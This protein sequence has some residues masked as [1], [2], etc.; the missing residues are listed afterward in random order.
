[1]QPLRH[2]RRCAVRLQGRTT[3]S[4]SPESL[5]PVQRIVRRTHLGRCIAL[6]GVRAAQRNLCRPIGVG[7][8]GAG[9]ATTKSR[10][11]RPG[12]DVLLQRLAAA[13]PSPRC[14]LDHD[15]PWTLLIA[16]ILSAQSTDRTVNSVTP[17]L[18][19]RWPTPA[20]LAAAPRAEV[21]HVV[22]RTGF[23]RNKAKAIQACSMELVA[24]HGGEVPRDMAALCALPGVARKTAN[25]VL[26]IACH[27][28]AGVV[29]DT[30]VTRVARR[31]ALTRADKADK[32]E[33]DL[34]ALLPQGQWI[35]GG[36]RLLLHGRYL[37]TSRS[38]QCEQCA[39]AELCP[40]RESDPAGSWQQRAAR[41]AALV[42]DGGE[43]RRP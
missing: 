13:I 35:E 1:M 32:I 39:L 14:E 11:R 36:H 10:G 33:Q 38:P 30:H 31:L 24:R 5:R 15:S 41:E 23:F 9:V 7:R 42:R 40:S 18:F 28:A 8:Y 6:A 19:R 37:C 12:V 26:G 16:T 17:E 2:G 20:A 25:V 21:E 4:N 43:L 29:V 27:V 34:C 3:T 22:H